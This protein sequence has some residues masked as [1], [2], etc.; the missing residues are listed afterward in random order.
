MSKD[1]GVPPQEASLQTD[2]GQH[3]DNQSTNIYVVTKKGKVVKANQLE[4]IN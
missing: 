4:Q 2:N 1:V 3:T